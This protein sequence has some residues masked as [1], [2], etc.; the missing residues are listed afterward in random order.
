MRNDA[1]FVLVAAA[2]FAALE[3]DRDGDLVGV[4]AGVGGVFVEEG[5]VV[6]WGGSVG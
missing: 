2:V 6:W 1:L 3:D 4:D 5:D